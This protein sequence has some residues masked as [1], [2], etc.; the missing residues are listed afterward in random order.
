MSLIVYKKLCLFLIIVLIL[1]MTQCKTNDENE[2]LP[3]CIDTSLINPD[4]GCYQ[5]YEPLCGCD[6][7]TYGNAC[8]ALNFAGVISYSDGECD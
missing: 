4:V 3:T 5:V 8:E 7:V 1:I 2:L 6:G